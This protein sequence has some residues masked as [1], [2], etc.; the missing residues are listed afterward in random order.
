VSR[1]G[2]RSARSSTRLVAD[3][4]AGVERTAALPLLEGTARVG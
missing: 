3:G 4:Q 2:R 1:P